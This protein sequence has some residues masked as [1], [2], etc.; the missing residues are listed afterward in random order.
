MKAGGRS[1]IVEKN[2]S[3]RGVENNKE[4]SVEYTTI[5]Y[6]LITAFIIFFEMCRRE[7]I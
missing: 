6:K 7:G 4:R 5:G 2:K 3:R 1:G